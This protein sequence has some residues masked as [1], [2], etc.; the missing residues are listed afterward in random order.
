MKIISPNFL[1]HIGCV[2]IYIHPTYGHTPE[3]LLLLAEVQLI[4]QL[5]PILPSL[6][7]PLATCLR[8]LLSLLDMNSVLMCQILLGY[9]VYT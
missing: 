7:Y 4:T 5:F 2:I 6:L 9:T 8:S 1:K 3:L